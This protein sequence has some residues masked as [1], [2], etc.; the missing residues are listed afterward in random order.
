[1]IFA[2]GW[3]RSTAGSTDPRS[4]PLMIRMLIV[5]YRYGI[6][7]ERR[8]CEE[9]ELQS[10]SWFCRLDFDDKPPDHSTFSVNRRGRFRDSDLCRYTNPQEV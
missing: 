1:M 6:R 10:P 5:G 7:F 4:T 3:C 9:V 8:P 2:R